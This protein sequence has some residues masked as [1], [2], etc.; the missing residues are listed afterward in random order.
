M[1][2]DTVIPIFFF[3]FLS[4][5]PSP[6]FLSNHMCPKH[7][8]SD[9][10]S[11]VTSD[12]TNEITYVTALMLLGISIPSFRRTNPFATLTHHLYSHTP[13]LFFFPPIST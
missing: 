5:S 13:F 8:T 6:L 12:M 7:M 3:Y 2:F 11:D 4:T 10:T 1:C 9:M